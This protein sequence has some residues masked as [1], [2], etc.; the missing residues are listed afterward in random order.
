MLD[1][2][3]AQTVGPR[4][5][6]RARVGLG[7]RGVA[8]PILPPPPHPDARPALASYR[9]PSLVQPYPAAGLDGCGFHRGVSHLQSQA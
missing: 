1:G 6:A 2:Q 3:G 8:T 5:V 7:L 4:E 9:L